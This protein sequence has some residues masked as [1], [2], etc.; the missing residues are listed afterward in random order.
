[1]PRHKRM[2]IVDPSHKPSSA[3]L[4]R[5]A[6]YPTAPLPAPSCAPPRT[7]TRTPPTMRFPPT[8]LS[9]H[10]DSSACGPTV[11]LHRTSLQQLAQHVHAKLVGN[12]DSQC[13]IRGEP[14]AA[15]FGHTDLRTEL[16]PVGGRPPISI[17]KERPWPTTTVA[18][19]EGSRAP[20]RARGSLVRR[21][22]DRARKRL[23]RTLDRI[24]GSVS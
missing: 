11:G 17:A 1:M 6:R 2:K 5:A 24:R 7:F 4:T 21:G 19:S 13:Q 15:E 16:A 8:Y 3:M 20:P 23:E 9:A 10:L 22:Q 12:P 14:R 18:Q